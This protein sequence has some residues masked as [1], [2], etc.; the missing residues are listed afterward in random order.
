LKRG[1]HYLQLE[2]AAIGLDRV[3][4]QR[5]PLELNIDGA[6]TAT[7]DLK[8][9]ESS[10]ISGR[11]VVYG[12]RGG[13]TDRGI[14]VEESENDSLPAISQKLT[15]IKELADCGLLLSSGEESINV[16]T[17]ADGSFSA[18]KLRPGVWTVTARAFNLPDYHR[19]EQETI[20]VT[21][22]PGQTEVC[23]FRVVP[24][25]RRLLITASGT[26]RVGEN[27]VTS[28]SR[29]NE[30]SF[31]TTKNVAQTNRTVNDTV[32]GRRTADDHGI[33]YVQIAAYRSA[34]FAER[35]ATQLRENG[36][37]SKIVPVPA[38]SGTVFQVRAG[39]YASAADASNAALK[40][41]KSFDCDTL[42]IAAQTPAIDYIEKLGR[43]LADIRESLASGALKSFPATEQGE[44]YVQLGAYRLQTNVDR[45][46]TLL[47]NAGV[48]FIM[49]PLAAAADTIMQIRVGGFATE[50]ES[51][52]VAALFDSWLES[53]T[54][55][56]QVKAP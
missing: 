22:S 19:L 54:L 2:N 4:L 55:V 28:I 39:S 8:I 52:A 50:L 31:S 46:T 17:S 37:P 18:Q 53:P 26:L 14:L 3:P 45:I 51:R 13:N 5:M 20:T 11:V 56:I 38:R 29:T 15:P 41:T 12:F 43:H 34:N 7:V 48:R 36:Y 49:V 21:L 27:S 25:T 6:R 35:R 42:I 44:W 40:L 16:T 23:D 30:P 33:W 24:R 47:D 10:A 9:V 32:S 1:V